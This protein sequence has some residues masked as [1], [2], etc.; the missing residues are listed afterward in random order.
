MAIFWSTLIAANS[1]PAFS[2]EFHKGLDGSSQLP[3]WYFRE[4]QDKIALCIKVPSWNARYNK[5]AATSSDTGCFG[6]HPRSHSFDVLAAWEKEL[7][8]LIIAYELAQLNARI[9][10]LDQNMRAA[11]SEPIQTLAAELSEQNARAN[12]N[13]KNEIVE[14]LK[15]VPMLVAEEPILQNALLETLGE[16]KELA[17]KVNEAFLTS[18]QARERIRV[19]LKELIDE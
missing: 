14:R 10:S 1:G 6:T 7:T 16:N 18:P 3:N 12:E 4:N 19:L 17:R 5:V 9:A 2:S 15:L 11:V 8:P 13:L